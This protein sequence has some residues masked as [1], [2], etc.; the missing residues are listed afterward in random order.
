MIYTSEN[1]WYYWNYNK[2]P[3]SRQNGNQKFTTTFSPSKISVGN[4]KDELKK[5]AAST[6]D[7]YSDLKPSILFSGGLDSEIMLRSYLEIG[8]S[9]NVYVFRY[10][11]NYNIY[12]VS[13]AINICSILNI[14]YTIIDFNLKKFFENEAERYS[15]LS[16][17]DRPKALPYCKFIEIIDGLPILGGSDLTLMRAD[18]D[19]TKKGIWFNRCW[20]HDIGWSKF[21]RAIEKP[22][23]GEW[24]K[25][26]PGLVLSFLE[27]EWCKNLVNDRI[28]GKLGTNSSK[29]SGYREAYPDLLYRE[30]KTGFEDVDDM[31]N[32]YEEFLSK[33]YNGLI[34]RNEYDRPISEL[35]S[36]N[37]GT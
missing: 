11:N 28:Y 26:T 2:V 31:M 12:D 19:Y 27:L 33:K 16:Q 22:A 14:D 1:N 5:A 21:I 36:I 4:F 23:I 7:L 24:F 25:W 17:I 9:P 30:K 3:F 10:E 20:E 6:L 13:Y 29:I 15:E 34:F 32:E 35:E 37:G 18:D 8:A